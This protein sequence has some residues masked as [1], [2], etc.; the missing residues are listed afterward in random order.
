MPSLLILFQIKKSFNLQ[1]YIDIAIL[2]A[3]T[4]PH[5]Y[6]QML[7]VIPGKLLLVFLAHILLEDEEFVLEDIEEVGEVGLA[8]AAFLAD[9][10]DSDKLADL[11]HQLLTG[12]H[13]YPPC[14]P[15]LLF[16]PDLSPQGVIDDIALLTAAASDRDGAHARYQ[17]C[18]VGIVTIKFVVEIDDAVAQ[19]DQ[20]L[21]LLDG[22]QV[23]AHA[24]QTDEEQDLCLQLVYHAP[25]PLSRE[26]SSNLTQ[27]AVLLLLHLGQISFDIFPFNHT[28]QHQRVLDLL[29]MRT[30]LVDGLVI[31]GQDDIDALKNIA[32][33][34]Q[35]A[36]LQQ[37]LE[38]LPQR[39]IV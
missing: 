34:F 32:P 4:Y 14:L 2:L 24:E 5:T 15:P 28:Y 6:P 35:L 19:V 39:G 8:S 33:L 3:Y 21:L 37:S 31:D 38:P 16:P 10:I 11:P 12:H 1:N 20:V 17:Q 23:V 25:T 22:R 30:D 27:P 36:V 26:V 18:T 13:L 9:E 7:R 29:Q